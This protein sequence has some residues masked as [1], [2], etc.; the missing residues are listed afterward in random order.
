MIVMQQIVVHVQLVFLQNFQVFLW[1][2]TNPEPVGSGPC[3]FVC[4][5]TSSAVSI[6]HVT[7]LPPSLPAP[8]APLPLLLFGSFQWWPPGPV[9]APPRCPS[10][11]PC[12]G[13][14]RGTTPTTPLSL[15]FRPPARTG[16]RRRCPRSSPC[17]SSSL[18][19]TE[20]LLVT[21]RT[22]VRPPDPPPQTD[23]SRL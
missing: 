21:A 20:A 3:C 19:L 18:T 23:V 7:P 16:G 9:W 13:R 4:F 12:P 17:S 11:E 10:S 5:R 8:P 2:N 15:W 1:N 14:S 22:Q 6:T